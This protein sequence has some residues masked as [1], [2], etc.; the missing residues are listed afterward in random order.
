MRYRYPTITSSQAGSDAPA[1]L[2]VRDVHFEEVFGHPDL[3]EDR[4]RIFQDR[5]GV[6]VPRTQ[7]GQH[8]QAHPG[9]LR[10]L[11]GLPRGRMSVAVRLLLERRIRRRVMDQEVRVAR[12]L[13]ER[14]VGH[15]V[16]RVHNLATAPRRTQY[17]LW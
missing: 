8:E 10:G 11:R 17:V 6:L 14:L 3:R 9:L 2:G 13:D 16:A 1:S 12:H 7:V 15:R 5:R 4:L